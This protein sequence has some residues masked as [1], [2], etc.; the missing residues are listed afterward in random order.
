M[1]DRL[2]A[3]VEAFKMYYFM[4]KTTGGRDLDQNRGYILEMASDYYDQVRSVLNQHN[5]KPFFRWLAETQLYFIDLSE[6]KKLANEFASLNSQGSP[7]P[8]I[9]PAQAFREYVN[10]F[11]FWSR[12]APGYEYPYEFGDYEARNPYYTMYLVAMNIAANIRETVLPYLN[13]TAQ[14]AI[15]EFHRQLRTRGIPQEKIQE[16]IQKIEEVVSHTPRV[17]DSG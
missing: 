6:V 11:A 12:E 14:D 16:I 9:W 10:Q 8:R 7:K 17:K 1:N 2:K 3:F 4:K 5:F 13:L 15:V